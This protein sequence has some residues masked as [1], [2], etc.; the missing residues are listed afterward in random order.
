VKRLI[1]YIDRG[2]RN[3][4]CACCGTKIRYEFWVSDSGG[5]PVPMGSTCIRAMAPELYSERDRLIEAAMRV[6]KLRFIWFLNARPEFGVDKPHPFKN[7]AKMGETLRDYLRFCA[8]SANDG[9]F[10]DNAP[11]YGVPVESDN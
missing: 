9:W 11:M 1:D 7:R 3:G 6:E 8:L 2:A 5:D 10:R 4:A